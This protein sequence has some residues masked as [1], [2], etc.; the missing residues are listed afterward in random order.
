LQV[1][2]EIE[3]QISS[4]MVVDVDGLK[5]GAMRIYRLVDGGNTNTCE[6]HAERDYL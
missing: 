6:V 2:R 5:R 4:E 1:C 3:D